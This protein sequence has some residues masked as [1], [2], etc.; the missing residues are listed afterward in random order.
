MEANYSEQKQAFD[1]KEGDCESLP[2]W[3]TLECADPFLS[4]SLLLHDRSVAFLSFFILLAVS[5]VPESSNFHTGWPRAMA[6]SPDIDNDEVLFLFDPFDSRQSLSYPGE[7]AAHSEN[8]MS[9]SDVVP[10]SEELAMDI[11]IEGGPSYGSDPKG[12]AKSIPMAIR[13]SPMVH[14]NFEFA[15]ANLPS[16]SSFAAYRSSSLGMAFSPSTSN[17]SSDFGSLFDNK[18]LSMESTGDLT[19]PIIET[20]CSTSYP[21]K[22]KLREDFPML[23]PLN[24]TAMDLDCNPEL[25]PSSGLSPYGDLAG[26]PDISAYSLSC[27]PET[28]AFVFRPPAI[29][30]RS[31]TNLSQRPSPLTASA[32]T[33]I[34]FQSSFG[35]SNSPSNISRQLQGIL[36]HKENQG[37]HNQPST[38]ALEPATFL[39]ISDLH[40]IQKEPGSCPPAW[41]TV[42]KPNDHG[43][44]L[45][46][47]SRTLRHKARSQSS[48]F[49]TS[50]LDFVPVTA[51]DV[52]E[53]LPVATVNYFDLVL[54][55]E[56]RLQIFCFLVEIHAEEHQ[57]WID[58]DRMTFA[59]A[60]S[61]RSRWVGRDRGI[62][63]LFKLS[64]VCPPSALWIVIS[65]YRRFLN[66][67]KR[68]L[69]MVSYGPRLTSGHSRV[70][71][72]A[73]SLES[74][75]R[76]APSFAL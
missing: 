50:V 32:P 58:E 38:P 60:A 14:D 56:L 1:R 55:K 26:S 29:R 63:E 23:P 3:A 28:A 67:G 65:L 75:I 9:S 73:S 17:F 36:D 20:S 8:T 71:R 47:P 33:T 5:K 22:G 46:T 54:P 40:A 19:C 74:L 59:K 15:P 18:R 24:F 37:P 43:D 64:R 25:P 68:S 51:T 11:D 34:T 4:V 42:A 6:N 45:P 69:L 70:Y 39:S 49:P 27:S 41:Y 21:G 61:S 7:L 12:K 62:R 57:R 10:T 52:F 72:R 30:C 53:P 76:L 16:P 66:H 31:L 44:L 35:S 48:P 2:L 13:P